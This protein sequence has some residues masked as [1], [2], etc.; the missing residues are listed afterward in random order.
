MP[1]PAAFVGDDHDVTEQIGR[2]LGLVNADGFLEL[3]E[4]AIGVPECELTRVR[5]RQVDLGT[6]GK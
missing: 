5:P 6:I 4:E 3:R 1:N 2:P